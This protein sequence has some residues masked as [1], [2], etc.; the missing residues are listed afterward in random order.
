MANLAKACVALAIVA[1]I[2]AVVSVFT[3][4]V[5]VPAEA[6]SRAST[7]LALIAL[8]LLLAFKEESAAT[9]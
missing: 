8:G 5:L 1:F 7:N 4:P 6:Y 2:M 9:G 3:G